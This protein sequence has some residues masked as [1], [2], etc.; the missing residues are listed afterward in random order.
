M[1][2]QVWCDADPTEMRHVVQWETF[3]GVIEL[4]A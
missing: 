2:D 3:D 4:G 1:I